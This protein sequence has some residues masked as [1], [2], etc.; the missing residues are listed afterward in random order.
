MPVNETR[1]PSFRVPVVEYAGK[2]PWGIEQGRA[3]FAKLDGLL[4]D[5]SESIVNLDLSGVARFDSSCAREII[6]NA[7]RKYAGM[8]WFFL[9]GVENE[10]VK[11]T[12]DAAM[13]KS[14]VSILVRSTKSAYAVLGVP[15]K[16]HLK[17]TLD[18][19]EKRGTA[20][21][22]EV[23][24]QLRDKPALNAC[25]NRLKD[26]VDAGLVMRVEG[27]AESGGREYVYLALR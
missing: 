4:R 25:I 24:A 12:I 5:R 2:E 13:L 11:E 16:E 6:T 15:L 9:S 22:K 18:I 7:L 20:T 1:F 8:R 14:E 19:I 10:S 23:A 27:S 17:A 21:S 3:A 26:L